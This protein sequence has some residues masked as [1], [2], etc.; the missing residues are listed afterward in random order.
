[1]GRCSLKRAIQREIETPLAKQIL[2]G[3]VHDGQVIWID[4]DKNGSGLT[5]RSEA[6]QPKA[7]HVAV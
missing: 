2:A 4:A 1:M 7:E 5:F 3:A 6:A